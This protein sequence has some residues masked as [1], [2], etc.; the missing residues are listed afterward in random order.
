[1]STLEA[2]HRISIARNRAYAGEPVQLDTLHAEYER[3]A[4]RRNQQGV[5]AVSP[6]PRSSPEYGAQCPYC[7]RYTAFD[8]SRL[9]QPDEEGPLDARRPGRSDGPALRHSILQRS[10]HECPLVKRGGH[11][12][13]PATYFLH[14]EPLT[15]ALIGSSALAPMHK[16]FTD[17]SISSSGAVVSPCPSSRSSAAMNKALL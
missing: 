16:G 10:F 3:L 11:P 9:L 14:D 7:L 1:M 6:P 15:I 13:L 12:V 17:S 4:A 8:E 5:R 2:G